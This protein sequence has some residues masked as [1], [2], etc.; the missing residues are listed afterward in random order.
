MLQMNV[1][2]FEAQ[3]LCYQ[4]VL[5]RG[6]KLPDLNPLNPKLRV[7]IELWKRLPLAVANAVGPHIVRHL[8]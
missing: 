7:F 2:G 6:D 8:G 5:R 4:Y 3:P 1:W